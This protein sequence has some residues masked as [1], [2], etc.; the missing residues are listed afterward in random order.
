M[1]TSPD[2]AVFNPLVWQIVRQVPNGA[3][4][5]YGQ[6]AS[7]I[8]VPDDIDA[9]DFRKLSPKW[10]GEALNAVSFR[11]ID[12]Q[13]VAPGVPWW[14]IINSRGGISMPRGSRAAYEQRARLVAE[15]V[16]FDA[17]GCVSLDEFGWEGPV[18]AWLDEHALLP[19]TPLRKPGSPK[20]MSLF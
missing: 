3:V 7:M 13:P 1:L 17:R 9:E 10:V 8:P 5:T 2:P 16:T 15:D 11:D 12:G 20:Q 18:Q 6:V 14:R 19:P 4:S